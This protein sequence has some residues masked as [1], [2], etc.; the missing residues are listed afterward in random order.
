MS[1]KSKVAQWSSG[2]CDL[3]TVKNGQQKMRGHLER[4]KSTERTQELLSIALAYWKGY[5]RFLGCIGHDRENDETRRSAYLTLNANHQ[6]AA[7]ILVELADHFGIDGRSIWEAALIC[8]SLFEQEPWRYERKRCWEWPECLGQSL[9]ELQ[10]DLREAIIHSGSVIAQIRAK[11]NLDERQGRNI[12]F[13]WMNAEKPKAK[14]GRP[15]MWDDLAALDNQMHAKNANVS[16]KEVIKRYNHKYAGPI[17]KSQRK[18]ANVSA[19][20]DARGYRR[21]SKITKR[22]KT[23]TTKNPTK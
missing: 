14:G 11:A 21:M 23:A 18:K 16:D 1:T 20:R 12:L 15:R 8:E 7:Q 3:E 17:G 13:R 10:P 2:G 19:L 9:L 22:T 6:A 4:L 5:T